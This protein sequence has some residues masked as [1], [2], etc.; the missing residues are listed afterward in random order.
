MVEILTVVGI[1]AIL[2]AVLVPT[3]SMVRRIAKETQQK[4]QLTAIELALTAF[5]SDYGDYPPS[6]FLDKA[7]YDY[8]GAQKLA[9]ALLG[10]DLLGFHPDSEWNANG[11]NDA[12]T[13]IYPDPLDPDDPDDR[14]NLR[15]RRGPYLDVANA[16]AFRLNQLFNVPGDFLD[17]DRFVIC[18]VFG[19]RRI[20]RTA[21]RTVRAG[22]PILY[23]RANTSSKT[24]EPSVDMEKR[25][26][27]AYDN[28]YLVTLGSL[29]PDGGVGKLHPLG[30]DLESLYD[31]DYNGGIRDPK[32]PATIRWPYRP[33]SY[34]LISAGAD[35]L[36]GTEDDICNF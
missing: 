2:V 27:N 19:V 11:K 10:W 21:G 30:M 9:E 35:G 5:K 6:D 3:L 32:I 17:A 15:A 12:G 29:T 31:Y 14:E 23:Y 20:T 18:D 26:Y 22:A 16:N 28:H 34:I 1:I 4:A 33:D 25:I 24:M 8:C 13:E 7:P 36:Y